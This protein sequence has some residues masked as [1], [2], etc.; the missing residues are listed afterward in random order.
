MV[1]YKS[2]VTGISSEVQYVQYLLADRHDIRH[3]HMNIVDRTGYIYNNA[4]ASPCGIR[5]VCKIKLDAKVEEV[6]S[7]VYEL[8]PYD[9]API[10]GVT[11]QEIRTFLGLA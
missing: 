3:E 2:R 1:T 4:P 5:P 10:R 9:F 7:G 6:E 11:S 8:L